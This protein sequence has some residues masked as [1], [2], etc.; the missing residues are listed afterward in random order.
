M[1]TA[2]EIMRGSA[3]CVRFGELVEATAAAPA[4]D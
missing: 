1:T 3:E 2:R 4:G